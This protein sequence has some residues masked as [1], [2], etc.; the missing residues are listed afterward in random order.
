MNRFFALMM[1]LVLCL[2]LC[3]CGSTTEVTEPAAEVIE[4]ESVEEESLLTEVHMQVIDAIRSKIETEEFASWEQL[5]SEFTGTKINL[6]PQ[7]INVTHYQI[8]DFSGEQVDCYLIAVAA[9]IAHWVDEAAQQGAIDGQLLIYADANSTTVIDNISTNASN[10]QHDTS[11]PM[12][13]ATYL[14]W[15]YGEA[16]SGAFEG[17]YVND[18]ETVSEM[19]EEELDAINDFLYP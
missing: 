3:A 10:L 1:A 12:G 7:V 15:I 9:N 8:E 5:Y 6:D 17:F 18:S 14:L 2:G 4:T 11:T 19:T 13:R 16:Q